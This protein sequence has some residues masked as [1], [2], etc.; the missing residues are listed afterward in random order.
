MNKEKYIHPVYEFRIC[1]SLQRLSID[2]LSSK[3]IFFKFPKV[4]FVFCF[5]K[6]APLNEDT[7]HIYGFCNKF[8]ARDCYEKLDLEAL[9]KNNEGYFFL[10]LAIENVTGKK[11]DT[12]LIEDKK[13]FILSG[14][15]FCP[16]ILSIIQDYHVNRLQLDTTW[17]VLKKIS[18]NY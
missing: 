15:Y 2:I 3:G 1:S 5:K 9:I 16:C 8:Q 14:T 13:Y 4:C 12:I 7:R 10:E 11:L 17:N 18:F 6:I